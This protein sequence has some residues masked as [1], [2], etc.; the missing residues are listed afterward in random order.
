MRTKGTNVRPLLYSKP[1]V[2]NYAYLCKL[3]SNFKIY[4]FIIPYFYHS[5][6]CNSDDD[7]LEELR[8][9][10]AQTDIICD[11]HGLITSER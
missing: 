8:D 9:I 4:S 1:S 5:L 3:T 10:A 2:Q 11:Y 7:V 6:K